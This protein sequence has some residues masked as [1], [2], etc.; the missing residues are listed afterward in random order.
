MVFIA[1][2]TNIYNAVLD[3]MTYSNETPV[4]NKYN[5]T[6]VLTEYQDVVTSSFALSS[7]FITNIIVTSDWWNQRPTKL[8]V[9]SFDSG[10][11]QK[12]GEAE[13]L[14][15][16][17]NVCGVDGN[18]K[19]DANNNN[20]SMLVFKV[21]TSVKAKLFTI[22]LSNSLA[23]Q[24]TN[25][26]YVGSIVIEYSDTPNVKAIYG[27]MNT[28]N[29][30]NLTTM[31]G[32]FKWSNTDKYGNV[33]DTIKK[34]FEDFNEDISNWN[35]SNV[36]TMYAM[37]DS[38]KV[39]DQN[40]RG[41]NVE[42]VT[43]FENIFNNATAM[44]STYGSL[45]NTE[46]NIIN[47]FFTVPIFRNYFNGDTLITDSTNKDDIYY[48]ISQSKNNNWEYNGYPMVDWD[49]SNVV[50]MYGLFSG[51]K[52]F[53][54]DISGW[55]VDNVTNMERM[56]WNAQIFNKNINN[57]NVSN[58]TNMK[59]M[60]MFTYAFNQ[61]LDK[62]NVS[63]VF[64][65]NQMFNY[66]S[67]IQ[68]IND[69]IVSNV[70]N[71]VGMFA[72]NKYNQPLNNWNVKNVNNMSS[73]F[74]KNTTFNKDISSWNVENVTN[75]SGMFQ[76]ASN[77]NQ[78]IRI[79]NIP[80]VTSFEN[81]F[82]ESTAMIN[83]YS[84]ESNNI[85]STQYFGSSPEYTPAK[86]FFIGFLPELEPEFSFINNL[87]LYKL[88]FDIYI[89][90]TIGEIGFYGIGFKNIN[91]PFTF[92]WSNLNYENKI[93]TLLYSNNINEILWGFQ[94]VLKSTPVSKD[95]T[96]T[97]LYIDDENIRF[98]FKEEP[99]I[100]T[101]SDANNMSIPV[102]PVNDQYEY[103]MLTGYNEGNWSVYISDNEPS[104]EPKPEDKIV[105]NICSNIKYCGITKQISNPLVT[106]ENNTISR[107]M[108]MLIKN[109]KF[110]RNA[111]YT[112][113]NNP[114]NKFGQRSGGPSGYGKPP[115]NTF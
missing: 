26:F 33:S 70:T 67:F 106:I 29:T 60:F 98:N 19:C 41:W 12:I 84:L 34:N 105:K 101:Y 48:A 112:I 73:M 62:W 15:Y 72:N 28:W 109:Q 43:S 49:V 8:E 92:P 21:N 45:I 77:F 18:Q 9:F 100:V 27:E 78:N 90:R 51:E 66:S 113:A 88:G 42:N 20:T 17:D 61:P 74:K 10:T 64:D 47:K 59:I 111:F 65:M 91:T 30:Q 16:H 3:W 13:I 96:S 40:I 94:G 68:N 99:I 35:T 103:K 108:S 107:R 85:N 44:Q 24:T 87:N 56:F 54:Q 31:K 71:M 89:Y 14:Q 86:E 93:I 110:S 69:W 81:M 2:D 76:S 75:M 97:W 39:F 114:V 6:D 95:D 37:F 83:I 38:A 11:S 25:K 102:L 55:I 50:N 57:W 58:V 7:S 5:I 104:P 1:D 36:T 82:N 32:L 22:K 79:W 4:I 53:N 52:N 80:N 23:S 63:K 115:K 46:Y